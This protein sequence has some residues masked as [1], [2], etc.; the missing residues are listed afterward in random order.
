MIKIINID[1]SNKKI[2]IPENI[3]LCIGNFSSLHAGQQKILE[4]A[5]KMAQ[6]NNF[7]L[8]VL[9]YKPNSHTFVR[10]E[11]ELTLIKSLER[12][13]ILKKYRV[14]YLIN[15]KFNKL[16]YY[17]N[18]KQFHDFL[19]RTFHIQMIV[20]GNDFTYG[21]KNDGNIKCLNESFNVVSCPILTY[22]NEKIST[23]FIIE[24]LNDGQV[25]KV[26]HLLKRPYQ[27][28]GPVIKNK[29]LGAKLGFP[30]CNLN[31]D[32]NIL[33]PKCG[34][35]ATLVQIEN[36]NHYYLGTSYIGYASS[37]VPHH[38]DFRFETYL[39]NFRQNIYDLNIK[40]NFIYYLRPDRFFTNI[41]F[42]K[43]Q[44]EKDVEMTKS[45]L[46]HYKFD[47]KI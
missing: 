38:K 47:K 31:T 41:K 13:N 35:Y 46:T 22:N 36:E 6:K 14:N 9:M 43:I 28:S 8:A 26:M 30:T 15:L 27:I 1:A 24:W 12:I 11:K 44:T 40:V 23:K 37:V 4:T 20:Q 34:I 45:L 7:Q 39:I 3:C 2:L 21:F 10:K 32:D 33:L 25:H 42:L 29:G 16:L 5:Q 18:A 17:F 19:M